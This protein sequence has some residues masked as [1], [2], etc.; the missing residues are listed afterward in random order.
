MSG[1]LGENPE[2]A[3]LENGAALVRAIREIE[4]GGPEYALKTLRPA[5][6]LVNRRN[7]PTA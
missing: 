7:N 2:G 4:V 3:R 6:F 5:I 1:G